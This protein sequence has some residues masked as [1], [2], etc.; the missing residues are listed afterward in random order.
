MT[1]TENNPTMQVA[2]GNLIVH[3]DN[4]V[5]LDQLKTQIA[6]TVQCV[7]IDPSYGKNSDSQANWHNYLAPR[8]DACRSLLKDSGAAFIHANDQHLAN[9]RMLCDQAFGTDNFMNMVILKTADP[10]GL[11]SVN[12]LP[13]NQTEYVLLY[14]KNRAAFTYYPQFV[15]S[16]YDPC[17]RS[18]VVNH[19]EPH[20]KWQV[21][22]LPRHLAKSL[23]YRS[24]RQARDEMNMQFDKHLAQYALEHAQ[25]VFQSTRVHPRAGTAI[26]ALEGESRKNPG[27]VICLKRDQLDDVFMRGGRQMTFYSKKLHQIDGHKVPTKQLTNLWTDIP[28]HGVGYE[29]EAKFS[30]GKKPERLIRRMIAICTQAGDLVLDPFAGSGSTAAACEKLGRRWIVIEKDRK[31]VDDLIVPRLTRVVNGIDETGLS[32]VMTPITGG[33]FQRFNLSAGKLIPAEK[34]IGAANH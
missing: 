15:E 18:I 6:Q 24:V 4:L 34:I 20:A 13:F 25:A 10:S 12:A 23:G 16:S 33:S 19:D 21:D 22:S 27:K 9:T 26:L 14:A 5:V 30:G 31:T 3:G 17:Y 28:F 2:P 8:I 11:R 29:G 1:Q 32:K 7:Y